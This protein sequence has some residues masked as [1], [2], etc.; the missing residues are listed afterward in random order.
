[1]SDAH[2]NLR[3]WAS[4]NPQ[5]MDPANR[6]NF[7]DINKPVIVLG[8]QWNTQ[9]DAL[10]LN[11]KSSIPSITSL[12]TKREVVKEFN[13]LRPL[14]PVTVQVKIFMQSLWQRNLDWDEPLS[15]EDQQQWLRIAENI[16]E[17]RYLQILRQYFPTIGASVQLGVHR[18]CRKKNWKN[19]S[20]K[21]M[22][23]MLAK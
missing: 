11:Y 8:L 4:I 7:A 20:A 5:L 18:F 14:S 2:F 13:P 22:S 16:E 12:I 21:A 1:M 15:D 10:S 17:A 3:S 23:K 6:D 19:R 9:T